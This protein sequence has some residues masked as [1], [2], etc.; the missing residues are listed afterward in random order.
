MIIETEEENEILLSIVNE[1]MRKGEANV[2][3][4]Q[5]RVIEVLAKSIEAY[6]EKKYPLP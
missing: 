5:S 2:T 4:Q 1:L 6:E 3:P